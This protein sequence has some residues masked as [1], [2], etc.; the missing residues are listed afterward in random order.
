MIDRF[1]FLDIYF[2]VVGIRRSV[3]FKM[4][5]RNTE[6]KMT[7]W[8]MREITRSRQNEKNYF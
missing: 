2:I 3:K 1:F 8:N 5:E 6:Q 7:R 4:K